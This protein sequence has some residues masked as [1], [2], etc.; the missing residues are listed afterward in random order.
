MRQSHQFV[1]LEQSAFQSLE[2]TAYLKGLLKPFKGN[3][4]QTWANQCIALRDGMIALAQRHLLPQA[5]SYPFNLLPVQLT[6]QTTGAGTTFLRWRNIDRSRMG[7]EL[8]EV[9]LRDSA[10]P[11]S[12]I[13]DLYAMEQQRIVFNMQMSGIHSIA[14]QA[15]DCANKATR[16]K[17]AYQRRVGATNARGGI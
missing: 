15:Q 16:A 3:G 14:R 6:L 8:W 4:L 9:L 1:A 17:A 2:H 12:L 5:R 13:D 10:T 7:V 11:E